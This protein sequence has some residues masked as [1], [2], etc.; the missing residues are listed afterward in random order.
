MAVKSLSGAA[1]QHCSFPCCN[2]GRN[3]VNG[4]EEDG[5]GGK[6]FFFFS[7]IDC[8]LA[9]RALTGT[10]ARFFL[11]PRQNLTNTQV[12]QTVNSVELTVN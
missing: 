6:V 2:N 12:S 8:H 1:S 11:T 9:R 3:N 7:T 10:F 4:S 5:E